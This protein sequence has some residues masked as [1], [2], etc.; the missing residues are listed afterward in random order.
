MLFIISI[1]GREGKAFLS[2]AT[3]GRGDFLIQSDDRR[4]E[5]IPFENVRI[6]DAAFAPHEEAMW[7]RF[8]AANPPTEEHA[9]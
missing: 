5:W 3:N 2:Y 6:I 1:E 9:H 4:A 8:R 7:H